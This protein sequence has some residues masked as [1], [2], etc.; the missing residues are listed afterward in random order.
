MG[1]DWLTIMGFYFFL[2]ISEKELITDLEKIKKV[3][4]FANFWKTST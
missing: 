4:V 3:Y 2:K 1:V